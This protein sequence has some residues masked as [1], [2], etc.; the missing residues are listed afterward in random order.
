MGVDAGLYMYDVVVKKIHLHY[1]ISWW[2]SC[3][4]SDCKPEGPLF[5]AEFVCLCVCLWLALLPFNVNRFWQNLV[6]RTLL[7]SS[8]AATIMVQIGRR[9]TARCL[10]E[11]FKKLS[12]I[13]EFEFQNSGPSFFA[14]VS[15][16]YCKKVRLDS[17]KTDRGDR[18]WSFPLWRFRQWHCCSKMLFDICTRVGPRK[19]VLA[20]GALWHNLANTIEPSMRGGDAASCQI[21]LI[22]CFCVCGLR[23]AFQRAPSQIPLRYPGR[24]QVRGWSQTCRRSRC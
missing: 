14:S 19:H 16:V 12:K 7:W 2:V 10:F 20:G 17:Y 6:T 11:N 15:S 9:G 13:T 1:L 8:L 21:T 18:F 24:R 5:S 4:W 22:T 23:S 3:Y